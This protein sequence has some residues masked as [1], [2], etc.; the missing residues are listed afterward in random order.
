LDDKARGMSLH[1]EAPPDFRMNPLAGRPF[2]KWFSE[3]SEAELV[4]I[5]ADFGEEPRAKILAREM[6]RWPAENFR[7]SR[8]LADAI[9]KALRYRS[10]SRVHP[11]TRSFQAFRIAINGELKALADFL[12]W[13]PARLRP[14]GRLCVISFHSLEDRIVKSR[15]RD[16]AAGGSFVILNSKPVVPR[17]DETLSN[18]RAR[19]AK[20]RTIESVEGAKH[21]SED[22]SPGGLA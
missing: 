12:R 17:E 2:E 20:M 21:G 6:K 22:Q 8:N 11:A 16:L 7:S 4:E 19:S 9:A 18:P 10:P 14:G 15:F 1:A 13:A 3:V 5:L